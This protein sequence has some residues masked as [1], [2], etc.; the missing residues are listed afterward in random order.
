[1]GNIFNAFTP[2]LVK[3]KLRKYKLRVQKRHNKTYV[4]G[5]AYEQL[6]SDY[7]MSRGDKIRI[8]FS[9]ALEHFLIYPETPDGSHMNRIEG[10]LLS[11]IS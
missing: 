7:A 6:I 9:N 11:Y 5:D 10:C 8:D 4:Y 3:Y 2:D 1:V